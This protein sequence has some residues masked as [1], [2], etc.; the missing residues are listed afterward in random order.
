MSERIQEKAMVVTLAISQWTARRYDREISDEIEQRHNA[1]EAGRYNKLLIAKDEINK[2]TQVASDARLYNYKVT[3]PWTDKG[4]RLLPAEL[5]F[6]Y[7]NKMEK[8]RSQFEKAVNNFIYQYYTLKT[9]AEHRLNTMYKEE[10]YPD[11]E[12]LKD[13]Y[14]FNINIL[15][16]PDGKDFRVNLQNEEVAKIQKD[17]EKRTKLTIEK[18][19]QSLWKRLY[20]AISRMADQLSNKHGKIYDSLIGNVKELCHLLP[21]LNIT[22]DKVLNDMK[23]EIEKKFIISAESLRE[24]KKYRQSKAREA[25]DIVNKM[26]C[27]MHS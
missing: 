1:Q 22:D 8:F 14:S 4:D 2:I 13:K 7:I 5:F 15:P 20:E 19:I 23:E 18:S 3:L 24:N 16:I 25:R 26:K 11:K 21:A 6:D 27:Y 10:D 17:I 9:E 12:S